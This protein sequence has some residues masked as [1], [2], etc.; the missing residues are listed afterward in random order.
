MISL[1]PPLSGLP[2]AAALALV[3][4]EVIAVFPATRSRGNLHRPVFVL[5]VVLAACLSFLSGYQASSQLSAVSPEVEAELGKHHSLGRLY[6]LSALALGAFQLVRS[7]AR[8]GRAILG[9][10]YYLA[11]AGVVALTLWVGA[12]GGRLV[13]ERGVGVKTEG[14]FPK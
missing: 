3:V 14:S 4:C 9:A 1:H 2:L 10:L 6:L 5:C 8:H 13:F 12:L 11:L 7:R